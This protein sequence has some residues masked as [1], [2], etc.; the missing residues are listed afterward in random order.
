MDWIYLF[1][2]FDGRI[3]RKPYWIGTIALNFAVLAA[4]F[5][6]D[7]FDQQRLDDIIY[8]ALHYPVFAVLLKRANDRETPYW[9]PFSYLIL[10]ILLGVLSVLGLDR[11]AD[12][13]ST[14]SWIFLIVSLLWLP[15]SLYLIFDLGFRR[16]AHGPNRFG[17]DPLEIHA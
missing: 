13:P 6:C 12:N 15:V 5:M 11:S 7:Y 2:S 14:V 16:G 8:L 4:Y 9:I 10:S 1:L 17:P 3:S